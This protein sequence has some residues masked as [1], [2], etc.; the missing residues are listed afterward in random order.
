MGRAQPKAV[1]WF[2][3]K[4]KKLFPKH[5]H[6]RTFE[7]NLK[8]KVNALPL[9]S[10]IFLCLHLNDLRFSLNFSVLVVQYILN[11]II[12]HAGT[13]RHCSDDR[14]CVKQKEEFKN[15]TVGNLNMGG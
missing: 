10:I 7:L 4:I 13:V 11:S 9:V 1:D 15:K 12:W 3:V 2:P 6:K 8:F 14:R 5:Q